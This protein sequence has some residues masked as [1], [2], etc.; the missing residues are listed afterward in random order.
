MTKRYSHA[1]A[2][3]FEVVSEHPE[4]EDFTVAMLKEALQKRIDQLGDSDEWIEAVGAP[5]DTYDVEE[6]R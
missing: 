1:V 4:G 3:G 2:I 5:Y 6:D